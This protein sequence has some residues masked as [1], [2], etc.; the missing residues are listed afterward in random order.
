MEWTDWRI[1]YSA[2]RVPAET[3]NER[4]FK[5]K[6]ISMANLNFDVLIQ[7]TQRENVSKE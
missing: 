4:G 7:F 6:C 2:D 1:I 5:E 3:H